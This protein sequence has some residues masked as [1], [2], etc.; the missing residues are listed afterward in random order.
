MFELI[1]LK[2]EKQQH[3][4]INYRISKVFVTHRVPTED[5]DRSL[6]S[7]KQWP[8]HVRILGIERLLTI[9]VERTFY[10][11]GQ[12][13][14]QEIAI[15]QEV[16]LGHG[17]TRILQHSVPMVASYAAERGPN[18]DASYQFV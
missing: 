10:F 11:G 9:R 3:E 16:R 12:A 1:W 17:F 15:S 7:G 13:F 2:K 4:V 14:A 5:A 6:H 8:L 18:A